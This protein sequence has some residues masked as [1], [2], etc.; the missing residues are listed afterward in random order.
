MPASL[1]TTSGAATPSSVAAPNNKRSRPS[2]QGNLTAK[3][4]HRLYAE[5]NYHDY[6]NAVDTTTSTTTTTNSNTVPQRKV[7]GGVSIPFPV[8]LYDVLDGI[9]REGMYED[10]VAWQ[11]HGRAF[12]IKDTKAFVTQVLPRY[13]FRRNIKLT[14]FQRQLN[15][16]G[17]GRLTKGPDAGCYYHESFLRGK[18]FLAWHMARTRVKGTKIKF[19]AN[20][21]AEPN[22]YQMVRTVVCDCGLSFDAEQKSLVWKQGLHFLNIIVVL[23][24]LPD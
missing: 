5:H 13:Y 21:A 23:S 4:N 7:G 16:Y 18:R 9:H 6:A 19:A 17:F 14:S 15:L 10:V 3:A 22:F 20:P 8:K 11:P 12:L 24:L 2:R 1:S